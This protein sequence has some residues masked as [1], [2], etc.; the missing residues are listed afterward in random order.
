[1]LV[2]EPEAD[3]QDQLHGRRAAPESLYETELCLFASI[4]SLL[5]PQILPNVVKLLTLSDSVQTSPLD[6]E[7]S[8]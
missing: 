4:L 6:V 2:T 8:Y 1:V 7:W 3:D 5:V